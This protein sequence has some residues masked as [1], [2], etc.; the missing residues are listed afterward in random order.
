MRRK[1]EPLKKYSV[2]LREGDI[3]RLQEL[4][5]RIGASWVIR[6]LIR[7]H[8]REKTGD[9]A[10]IDIETLDLSNDVEVMEGG[11]KNG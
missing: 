5:P 2:N 1:G 8:L 11:M 3:E 4:Y 9:A 10:Y 6:K 7:Q